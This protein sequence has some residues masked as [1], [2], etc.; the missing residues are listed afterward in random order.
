MLARAL[1][2]LMVLPWPMYQLR[3]D[4]EAVVPARQA[5]PGAVAWRRNLAGKVNGGLAIYRNALYAESFDRRITALA[6][7]SGRILWS[8]R[9]PDIAMTT[10]IVA[11]G[12]VA[13]GTG[14]NNE[15]RTSPQLVWGRPH[16]D[17]LL[18]FAAGTGR[19]LWIHRTVGE[20]MPS[21][22]LT[23]VDGHATIVFANGANHLQAL[24]LRT[25]QTLW[26]RAIHGIAT[27]SSAA[28]QGSR[29]YII[30]GT[31]P[32]SG[33]HD[34]VVAIDTQTGSVSWSAPYGNADCSPT[35]AAGLVFVE[36][37][38]SDTTRRG[39]GL[40]FNDVD[41]IDLRTGTLRW[42]WVSRD[43]IISTIGSNEQAIA[44]LARDGRFYESVPARDR[45]VAFNARNGRIAWSIRTSGAVKMSAVE[46][47]GTLYVGD[48]A[49]TFYAIRASDGSVLWQ[50]RFP[51]PFTAS[52]PV[53]DGT[54]LFVADDRSIYA[55]P[56]STL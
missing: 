46:W 8:R 9:L 24:S 15:L 12:I 43:G 32:Y 29:A 54:T 38:A 52:P 45:F 1:L 51:R 2:V 22:G 55:L 42:R 44:G 36:G 41:A 17:A 3:P 40:E 23:W 16:G 56:L 35:L 30:V 19:K 7:R 48:T 6:L 49:G 33:R 14:S 27:M 10:P 20:D 53:I 11:R 25:G 26:R 4:H 21:P 31:G 47:R 39:S 37:S 50:R 13:V 5:L 34:R 18:G 28:V